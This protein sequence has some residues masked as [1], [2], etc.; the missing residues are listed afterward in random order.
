MKSADIIFISAFFVIPKINLA[1]NEK[2]SR[3]KKINI[4]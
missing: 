2:N 1:K 4:V 3:M